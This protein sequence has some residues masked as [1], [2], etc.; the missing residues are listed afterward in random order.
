MILLP[1]DA[2]W[3]AEGAILLKGQTSTPSTRRWAGRGLEGCKYKNIQL[4]RQDD[5]W[6]KTCCSAPLQRPSPTSNLSAGWVSDLGLSNSFLWSIITTVTTATK[7][8]ALPLFLTNLLGVLKPVQTELGLCFVKRFCYLNEIP[9]FLRVCSFSS[10]T[11]IALQIPTASVLNEMN[12]TL[13]MPTLS[14]TINYKESNELLA[15]L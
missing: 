9:Y 7:N 4:Q 6:K 1:K 2:L 11:G 15:Q 10:K 3:R 5:H 14:L 12:C 8:K 13:K